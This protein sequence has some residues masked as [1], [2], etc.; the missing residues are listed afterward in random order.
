MRRAAL[1]A[2][3]WGPGYPLST[4]SHPYF[5]GVLEGLHELQGFHG[6]QFEKRQWELWL[7]C[8]RFR[9]GLR[10]SSALGLAVWTSSFLPWA[11]VSQLFI[12]S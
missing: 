1:A 3:G 12:E 6:G 5:T 10:A 9:S 8:L 11:S 4:V 2:E 7:L